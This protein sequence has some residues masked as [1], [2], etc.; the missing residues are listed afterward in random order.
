MTKKSYIELLKSVSFIG[1]DVRRSPGSVASVF[2]P[3]R[4]RSA[5]LLRPQCS[6]VLSADR[7]IWPSVFFNHNEYAYVENKFSDDIVLTDEKSDEYFQAFN[8][9]DKPEAMLERYKAS[10][11]GDCGVAFALLN[12]D[13]YAGD[14][15]DDSWFEAIYSDAGVLPSKAGMNWGFMGFDV[16]NSGF[17]SA[18]SG[19]ILNDKNVV[20]KKLASNLNDY[21]LFK[22]RQDVLP[23]NKYANIEM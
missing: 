19:F 11:S 16:V 17:Q 20:Q 9:W 15:D 7:S 23:F 8:L 4:R 18:I 5:C 22:S 1:F 12:P 21:C 2:M 3:A 13:L 14:F 10:V 6:V